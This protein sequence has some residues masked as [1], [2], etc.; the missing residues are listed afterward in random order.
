MCSKGISV[1]PSLR[2][3]ALVKTALRHLTSAH[4]VCKWSNRFLKISKE[5][6]TMANNHCKLCAEG[7]A[8]S[9]SH[10]VNIEGTLC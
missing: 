8:E 10:K 2:E 6:Q 4:G 7:K 3:N 1:R 5:W 9:L